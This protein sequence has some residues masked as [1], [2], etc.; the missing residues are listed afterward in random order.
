MVSE[1]LLVKLRLPLLA[2]RVPT[3]LE[4]FSA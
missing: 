4:E 3:L 1:L 2:A